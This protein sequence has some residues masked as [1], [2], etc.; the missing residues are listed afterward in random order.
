MKV[1]C[2]FLPVLFLPVVMAC[3]HDGED[4]TPSP[5]APPNEG[6]TSE[7]VYSIE[8]QERVFGFTLQDRYSYCP[9]VLL[10]GNGGADIYFCGNPTPGIMIDNIYHIKRDAAG[11]KTTALSVLK[12]GAD[13]AWDN[14]HTCDPSVIAGRFVMDGTEYRYAMFY[15]GCTVQWYYNEIGVAFANSLDAEQ[16]VKYPCQI[17]EKTWP[18]EGEQYY[19][20]GGKS[21][22]VGQPSAISLDKAGKV[23]LSYTIGDIEGT[24]IVVRELDL[25][26]MNKPSIG[27]AIMVSRAG[28]LNASKTDLD[29]LCNADIALD[30]ATGTIYMI[31]P[32]QPH[33]STYPAYIN[34]IL[35]LDRLSLQEFRNGIGT[36][37][38][39]LR[40]T[41]ADTGFP[42]NHNAAIARDQ[43]G[44]LPSTVDMSLYYTVSKADPDVSP[45]VGTHAEWTYDIYEAR[46]HNP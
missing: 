10:D 9:S 4:S 27:T 46:I 35:E 22:G 42:R 29:Y 17:I 15:L 8:N 19:G 43:Y 34:D 32:V 11:K 24:R 5:Q 1:L 28:L 14:Q 2:K 16:W 45:V 12:P 40:L 25:S 3:G 30:E 18:Q 37:T 39:L 36:W 6:N 38:P 21:W 23:L 44:N 41:P 13:P 33:S 26:D 7:W 31:R 20:N